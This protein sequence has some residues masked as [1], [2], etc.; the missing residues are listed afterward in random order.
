MHTIAAMNLLLRAQ[1]E[2]PEGFS[3]ATEEFHEG[4]NFSRSVGAG[5]LEKR[6]KS[7][8]WN[9]IKIEVDGKTQRSGVGDTAQE[10]IASALKLAL[11]H[12]CEHFNAVEVEHI[13][14]TQY[15]WFFLARVKINPFR[16][17]QSAMLPWP[18][19]LEPASHK[20][21]RKRLS[22]DPSVPC[23]HSYS[24]TPML[25][26]MLISSRSAHGGIQ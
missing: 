5:R 16:I 8:G 21:G 13:E 4:W 3:L 14:L 22:L 17:Q 11:R 23:P 20:P 2:L 6:L 10:A 7:R 12:I 18:D 25:K 1:A 9:I 19:H 15:P 24:I 26:E